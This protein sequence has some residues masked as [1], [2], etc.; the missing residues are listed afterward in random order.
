LGGTFA[1]LARAAGV[2]ARPLR[3]VYDDGPGVGEGD[4]VEVD[5]EAAAVILEAFAR[6]D[7]A[8]RAFAPDEP[9]VLWPEHF[10]IGIS[11]DEVNY[12]VS[13]GDGYL[14]RPYAEESADP[15][16]EGLRARLGLLGI[17]GRAGHARVPLLALPV[18]ADRLDLLFELVG[19][20]LHLVQLAFRLLSQPRPPTSRAP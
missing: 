14:D 20:L 16:Q 4:P 17:T 11:L 19:A 7:A 15:A 6:A 12:G 8:L 2:E 5:S 13:P 18:L 10:D 3:D 9:P 1:D